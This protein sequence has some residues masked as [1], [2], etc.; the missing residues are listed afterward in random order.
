MTT[1]VSGI[2]S[3]LESYEISVR[4]IATD[5]ECSRIRFMNNWLDAAG[6][7][8]SRS[9]GVFVNSIDEVDL[10]D[11]RKRLSRFGYDLT[12]SELGCFLAHEIVGL[13]AWR[14]E[15]HADPRN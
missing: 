6:V 7:D 15:I 9:Q 13:S 4:F 11:S 1:C 3:T 5:H 14:L 2:K 12:L 8:F 10:Y